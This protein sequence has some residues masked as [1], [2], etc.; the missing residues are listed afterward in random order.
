MSASAP[1]ARN[2]LLAHMRVQIS[3]RWLAFEEKKQIFKRG[4]AGTRFQPPM[5]RFDESQIVRRI[6]RQPAAGSGKRGIGGCA[7]DAHEIGMELEI[8][9]DM[10]A[11][12]RIVGRIHH[13]LVERAPRKGI[14]AFMGG[15]GTVFQQNVIAVLL[16]QRG[17]QMIH[18]SPHR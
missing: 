4:F 14:D 7:R 9:G 16:D 6:D 17:H 5:H 18:E 3:Q 15:D 11:R 1:A 8:T 10:F 2:R 12:D 13:Q